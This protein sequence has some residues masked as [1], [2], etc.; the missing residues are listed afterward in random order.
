[1]ATKKAARPDVSPDAVRELYS[2]FE[3]AHLD[4]ASSNDIVQ[5]LDDWFTSHGYPTVIYR[6]RRSRR[7][8]R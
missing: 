1:M 6:P 2:E 8:R 4:E 7:S 3:E 5:I